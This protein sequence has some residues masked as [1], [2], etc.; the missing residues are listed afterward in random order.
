[1]VIGLALGTGVWG[2]DDIETTGGA[3][4]GRGWQSLTAE[5]RLGYVKGYDDGVAA[6]IVHVAVASADKTAELVP[7]GMT[8]GEVVSAV[9]RFYQE[10][11]NRRIMVVAAIRV[12]ALEA[13]G[14]DQARVDGEIR[15][16]RRASAEPVTSPSGR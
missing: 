1:M 13:K 8:V 3:I 15:R 14:T 16:L 5:M 11:L 2:A 12:V 4:N 9:D 10:P 6:G 7:S